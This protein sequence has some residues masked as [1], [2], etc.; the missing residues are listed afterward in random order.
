MSGYQPD[1]SYASRI[2]RKTSP[3]LRQSL[4]VAGLASALVITMFLC[5]AAAQTQTP[6][7]PPPAGTAGSNPASNS[8]G[9]QTGTQTGSQNGAGQGNG[10]TP[11]I[12]KTRA[13]SSTKG[14][15]TTNQKQDATQQPEKLTPKPP[16]AN[17]LILSNPTD[18]A[19]P[20]NG[21][22]GV[23]HDYSGPRPGSQMT[24]KELQ[25]YTHP[26]RPAVVGAKR[27]PAFGYDYFQPARDAVDAL[28]AYYQGKSYMPTGVKGPQR[29]SQVGDV[30]SIDLNPQSLATNGNSPVPLTATSSGR[31][32]QTVATDDTDSTVENALAGA[33]ILGLQGGSLVPIQNQA[34]GGQAY[35]SGASGGNN[36]VGYPPQSPGT[37]GARGSLTLPDNQES[38]NT[39]TQV[40]GPIQ[41]QF[42]NIVANPPANYQLGPGDIITIAYTAPTIDSTSLRRTIDGSGRV[43]LQGLGM[44]SLV[45]K[46]IASAEHALEIQFRRYFKSPQVTISLD[47]IH[48]ISVSVVGHAYEPG[49]YSVPAVIAT[50]YNLLWWA[51]G[52]TDDG[53][54]RDVEV[55]RQGKTIGT[56]DLYRYELGGA[57]AGDIHLE[58]GD[59]LYIPGK[60]SSV[61]VQ[62]EV[63]TQALYELKQGET[64]QDALRFTGGVKASAVAQRIQINTVEPGASRVIR[65]VD[66]S[67][68]AGRNTPIYDG[69]VVEVLSVRNYLTNSVTIEGAVDQPSDYA[70]TPNMRVSD[71]VNRA[72]GLLS[73][74]YPIAE[75]HH[76]NADLTDT[77]VRID[78]DKALAHDPANDLP[79]IRWDRIKVYTREEVAWTGRHI[80]TVDGEVRKHG[81]YT[82]SNNMHV[83]DA[84]RMAGGPMPDAYLER[85]VLIHQH[86][87][88][89]PTM[90][91]VNIGA[92]INGDSSK[93]PLVLDNDHLA[94]YAVG[95]AKFTPDHIV[96][97][98]GEV[99]AP[100]PYPRAEDMTITR[101]LAVAGGFKPNAG[102]TVVV[103]HARR[104]IDAPGANLVS[105]AISFDSTG[106]CPPGQDLKLEDGDVVTIQGKGGYVD[107]VQTV[108]VSGAVNNPGPIPITTKDM[109]LSDAITKAGGLRKEAYPL[110]AE[111]HRDPR[112]MLTHTQQSMAMSIGQLRDLLNGT[113][114]QRESA[115]AR[116]DVITAT[117]EAEADTASAGLLGGLVG[118]GAAAALPSAAAGAVSSQLAAGQVPVSPA[119]P[120]G[121][122]QNE[123]DGAL[124]IN[125]PAALARPGG[126]E[127]ILLK[128]GDEISVPETL[129]TVQLI[130]AVYHPSGVVWQP[131]KRIDYY[132]NRAGGMTFDAAKDGIEVIRAGGGIVPAKRAQEILP[133]DVILVPTKPIAA[134]ISK[135]S[136]ALNDFFKTITSSVLI[137]G[138]A[139]S[140]FGL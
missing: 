99:V 47:E 33:S 23:K 24:S 72:R 53:S 34:N 133:G 48:T 7:T 27:L 5:R 131:G 14:Q 78:V 44:V 46:T 26:T 28:R 11:A 13:A 45:G 4:P 87:D 97:V 51:G 93:D 57:N 58:S 127:D 17:P 96:V 63:R 65:D 118:G 74:A 104:V 139:R 79:L 42:R 67:T 73:Q 117:G 9:T 91:F 18:Q 107:A 40:F 43:N 94:V 125:L 3:R 101:L 137:Y 61:A 80:I 105:S 55:R 109:R 114:F 41:G 81:I 140:I 126:H 39:R 70:L 76:L 108:V 60:L 83:S 88:G 1:L 36:T 136:N 130:G 111:F 62:G 95:Q 89:P 16:A 32:P 29:T 122:G 35:A 10:G 98:S 21:D 128:N 59:V 30:G 135:H 31:S 102:S 123:P 75:L 129:N 84:L 12:G 56:L 52:P 25:D 90:E 54:L 121:E 85:A 64:L 20:L 116:L 120:M 68:D 50:A 92:I 132:I 6:Q 113:A 71:L 82:A 38:I 86:E 19:N 103:T 124:A 115:K 8:G 119:R 15:P 49:A 37:A 77:L 69:D 100:G 112:T 2:R 66:V 138:V 22:D 134:S 106:H 110:G